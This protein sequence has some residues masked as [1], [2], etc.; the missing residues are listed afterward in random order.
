MLSDSTVWAR[1][2][3]APTYAYYKVCILLTAVGGAI[4]FCFR[5]STN[6]AIVNGKKVLFKDVFSLKGKGGLGHLYQ[7]AL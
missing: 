6:K 5:N 3:S 2:K 7:P 4:I 1:E